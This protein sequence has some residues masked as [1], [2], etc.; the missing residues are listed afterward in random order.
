MNWGSTASLLL[1]VLGTLINTLSFL[2]NSLEL[3]TFLARLSV[4][5]TPPRTQPAAS[6]SAPVT[7]APLASEASTLQ[8]STFFGSN[9]FWPRAAKTAIAIAVEDADDV[10]SPTPIGT[11]DVVRTLP[12][13]KSGSLP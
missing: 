10:L 4:M 9:A 1:L 11:L 8:S 2:S 6:S 13:N 3:T 7:L 5:F 12:E